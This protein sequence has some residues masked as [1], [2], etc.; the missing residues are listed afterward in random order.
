MKCH[1]EGRPLSSIPST[2]ARRRGICGHAR[3]AARGRRSDRR[4]TCTPRPRPR[5]E[6]R[7][8]P[9]TKPA[10]RDD[11]RGGCRARCRSPGRST[12]PGTRQEVVR[13]R[14]GEDE[15]TAAF[16]AVRYR[17]DRSWI[18]DGDRRTRPAM[19]AIMCFFT[20]AETGGDGRPPLINAPAQQGRE[21]NRT[22]P[23]GRCVNR[24]RVTV[25][26]T[27]ARRRSTGGS[28]ARRRCRSCARPDGGALPARGTAARR[29]CSGT[30]SSPARNPSR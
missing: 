24:E 6:G 5:R 3:K 2:P 12:G 30:R 14:G 26:R 19:M 28:R 25:S 10:H 29:R 9:A 15:P 8:R 23:P 18:D 16:A 4:T 21:A 1:V 22:E 27:P 20:L 13:M 7:K 17:D 11:A